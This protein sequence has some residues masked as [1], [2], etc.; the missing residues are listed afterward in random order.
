M[1]CHDVQEVLAVRQRF[2]VFRQAAEVK[3]HLG[4]CAACRAFL[5]DVERVQRVLQD[6]DCPQMPVDLPQRLLTHRRRTLLPAA[7]VAASLVLGVA[8]VL[9][10]TQ[11]W[12]GTER[13]PPALVYGGDWRAET[14]TLSLQSERD[15]RDVSI[16]LELPPQVEV[17]GHPGRRTLEWTDDLLAGPNK[18]RV[19]LVV[20][21]DAQGELVATLSHEGRSRNL[22]VPIEKVTG[23]E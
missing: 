14:V 7:A 13:E 15:L 4:G 23:H 19:P 18:L 6:D 5:A 9:G 8:L 11:P 10:V 12:I 21:G 1:K 3:D 17:D 20:M 16:R 22:R 2:S